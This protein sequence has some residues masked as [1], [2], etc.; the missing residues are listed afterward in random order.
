VIIAWDIVK[1]P[2]LLV[3]VSL[4]FA[5]LYWA[6]PNVRHPSFRWITPGGVAAV[7]T[8]IV[9][10]AAFA[11]YVANFA[12]YNK[13]YGTLG[14]II[15][16]LV[17]LWISNLAILFGAELNAELQRARAIE[18]GEDTETEPFV[19]PRDKRKMSGQPA[20]RKQAR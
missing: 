9:A 18:A 12:S 6:A 17:W 15:A 7:L 2:V 14:G 1:W 19:E 4:I 3:I 16:F 5:I 20:P 8:W 13:T 11:V 10:S